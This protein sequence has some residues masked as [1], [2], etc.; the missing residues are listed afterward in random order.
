MSDPRWATLPDTTRARWVRV[1][2]DYT[3][4]TLSVMSRWALR[5]HDWGFSPDDWWMLI[6]ALRAEI[7]DLDAGAIAALEPSVWAGWPALLADHAP[8][9]ALKIHT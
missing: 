4:G 8:L 7:P 3:P 5:W 2:D 6:S 1:L 9:A